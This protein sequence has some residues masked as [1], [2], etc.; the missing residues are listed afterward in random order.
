MVLG[1]ADLMDPG[2]ERH[3]HTP[4]YMHTLTHGCHRLPGGPSAFVPGRH[5]LSLPGGG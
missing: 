2:D 5:P 1:L 3:L 4:T